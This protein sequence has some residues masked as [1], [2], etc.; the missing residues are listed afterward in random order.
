MGYQQQQHFNYQNLLRQQQQLQQQ[1]QQ[2]QQRQLDVLD[3]TSLKYLKSAYRVGMLGLE[4]IAKR[5]DGPQ[6]K[7]RQSPPF[8]D[9]VKWLCEIAYK[10]G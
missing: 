10:L 9:D 7:Y 3:S 5:T 8:A 1:Q 6:V 4:A 2:L